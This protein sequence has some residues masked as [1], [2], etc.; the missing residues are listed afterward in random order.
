MKIYSQKAEIYLIYT[1]KRISMTALAVDF[2]DS[3]APSGTISG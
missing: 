1:K 3:N 2:L